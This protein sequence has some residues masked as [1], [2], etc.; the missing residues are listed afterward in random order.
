MNTARAAR[1]AE[2]ERAFAERV[3]H[4]QQQFLGRPRDDRNHHHAERESAGE[5]AE[6]PERQHRDAVREHADHDRR[7][8]VQ[9]VG[10]EPHGRWRT[11]LPRYS[12]R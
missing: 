11:V 3:R 9:R 2:R 1:G 8:A 5:R 4:E 10:G 12:D 6:M 7:H